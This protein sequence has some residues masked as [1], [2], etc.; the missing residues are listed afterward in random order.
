LAPSADFVTAYHAVEVL[1]L[2][3]LDCL[4][5]VGSYGLTKSAPDG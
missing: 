3:G 2:A 5:F 1:P 4:R